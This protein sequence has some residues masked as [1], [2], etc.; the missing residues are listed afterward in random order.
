MCKGC[1]YYGRASDALFQ[2]LRRRRC[3]VVSA[4]LLLTV[5]TTIIIYLLGLLMSTAKKK[6]RDARALASRRLVSWTTLVPINQPGAHALDGDYSY[7]QGYHYA[8][9]ICLLCLVY[10]HIS[11]TAG[12]WRPGEEVEQQPLGWCLLVVTCH[13]TFT[14]CRMFLDRRRNR[15]SGKDAGCGGR[16]EYRMC[17]VGWPNPQSGPFG[18]V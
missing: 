9:F 16:K 8:F 2:A 17:L 11:V 6:T 15:C 5:S 18:K 12:C 14:T 4:V 7:M 1:A 10:L 13:L 3:F